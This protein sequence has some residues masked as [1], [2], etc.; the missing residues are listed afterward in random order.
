MNINVT[1]AELAEDCFSE[2]LMLGETDKA[3]D[4]R[5][6]ETV[7][8]HIQEEKRGRG[9]G[10]RR[11][12]RLVALV[13]VLATLF[14]VTAYATGLFNQKLTKASGTVSGTWTWHNEDGSVEVQRMNYPE[15]GYILTAEDTGLIPN[16]IELKANWLPSRTEQVGQ[17]LPRIYDDGGFEGPVPYQICTHYAIPGFTLVLNGDCRIVKEETWENYQVTELSAAWNLEYGM[18]VQNFVLLRD[19]EHGYIIS[20]GGDQS[21]ETLEHMA[22]ELEVRDTGVPVDY[23]PNFNIG[24]MNIGRG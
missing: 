15:A 13:A 22:K 17:W 24:I 2:E 18:G 14:T 12:I 19:E 4:A 16:K 7:M 5:I 11:V 1:W 9:T 3:R 20:V 23:D 10:A 8:K 21:F 6:K